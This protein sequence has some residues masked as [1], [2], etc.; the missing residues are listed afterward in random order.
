[1]T[2]FSFLLSWVRSFC[3]WATNRMYLVLRRGS[4]NRTVPFLSLAY[5]GAGEL[6]ASPAIDVPLVVGWM[7]ID[8]GKL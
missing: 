2:S 4:G 3:N 1:M 8:L 6:C 7:C 5:Q